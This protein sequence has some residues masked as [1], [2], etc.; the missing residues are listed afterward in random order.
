MTESG[1]L[2]HVR[3]SVAGHEHDA[4]VV[5]AA[6]ERLAEERPFIHA[7]RYRPWSAEL[8]YW[9][10]ADGMLDAASLALRLWNE[11]RSS[12]GLPGWEVVGLEVLERET[13]QHRL[14]APPGSLVAVSGCHPCP[15]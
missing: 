5:C 9:E 10:Q 11:H 13:F 6:L 7:M 15:Y 4:A 14:Q 12:C 8:E 2:W 3:V 1:R